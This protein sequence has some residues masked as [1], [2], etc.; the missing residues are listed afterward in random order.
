MYFLP[1]HLFFPRSIRA[2]WCGTIAI[3]C[4][5]EELQIGPRQW[6]LSGFAAKADVTV[7][8]HAGISFPLCQV[9]TLISMKTVHFVLP[10][11]MHQR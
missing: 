3:P 1:A 7:R 9:A 4:S 5:A 2:E 11:A 10:Y 8:A 6:H